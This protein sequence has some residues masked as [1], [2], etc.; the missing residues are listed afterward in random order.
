[1]SSNLSKQ[2]VVVAAKDQVSCDL[3]GEAA[4]LNLANG[5]YYGLD[6]IGARV[7]SLLQQPRCVE[8]IRDL[9]LQ[10]YEVEPGRCQDDLLALLRNLHAQGLIEVRDGRTD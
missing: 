7:W 9:V 6:T 1:M 8:E 3:E 10:E 5:I 4:I 2:S